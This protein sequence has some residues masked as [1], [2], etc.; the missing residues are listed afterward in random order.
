MK[1]DTPYLYMPTLLYEAQQSTVIEGLGLILIMTQHLNNWKTTC[2]ITSSDDYYFYCSLKSTIE[3][4][5][6]V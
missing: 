1:D 3:S 4:E 6:K 5:V 2:F